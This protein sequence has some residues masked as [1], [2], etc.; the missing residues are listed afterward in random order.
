MLFFSRCEK[1]HVLRKCRVY[2][3]FTV[4]GLLV[5]GLKL[6]QI[7]IRC[8]VATHVAKLVKMVCSRD[9]RM[10]AVLCWLL[11]IFN[12]FGCN[13][14]FIDSFRNKLFTARIRSTKEGNVFTLFVRPREGGGTRNINGR[15]HCF[16]NFLNK[17][18]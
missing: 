18:F 12:P 3:K 6:T 4:Q 1:L 17:A 10:F 5:V 13:C 9:G 11:H 14:I 8:L 2:P 16:E 15:L 7:T